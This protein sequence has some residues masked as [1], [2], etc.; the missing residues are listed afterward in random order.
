MKKLLIALLVLPL[1][2]MAQ[3]K[4][5]KAQPKT[6]LTGKVAIVTGGGS[7]IGR[8][9]AIRY[10]QEGAKVIIAGRTEKTLKETAAVHP[11][12]SYVVADITKTEQVSNMIRKV[13][14]D[15]N[16]QLDILVNNA[17]WCPVQSIKEVTLK[18][19]DR[20]FDLDVRALVDV[21]IQS[22]PYL[23]KAK[24]NI[25]N[26]ST[27]GVTNR[28]ANLSMYIGAKSAVEGFTRVW[29]LDLATDGVRVNAIA[30]GAID[31]NIWNVT[32]LSPEEERKHKEGITSNIPMKR[33]GTSEEVAN[34]AL[35]LA[36]DEA[37]YISGSVLNVDGGLGAF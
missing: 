32:N 6:P 14:T 33:F 17:G 20:A 35:F 10:A 18:D 30:P 23:I 25:I 34:L 36:S 27:V 29:A 8:A 24:G 15:Y 9:I 28:G 19:Y 12:I 1:F 2:A 3:Q 11:N 7:G 37:R 31:T 26:L 5:Q 21:T 4:Q 13:E 16:G 22:L